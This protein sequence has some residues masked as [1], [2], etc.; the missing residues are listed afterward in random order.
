[1][2]MA[3]YQYGAY[4]NLFAGLHAEINPVAVVVKKVGAGAVYK[5]GTAMGRT[6][7]EA[8][9]TQWAGTPIVT[10]ADST[11]SDGSQTVYGI[12]AD[13]EGVDT[14]K[15]DVRATVY[16]TGEFNRDALI[17]GGTDKVSTH[18][19]AMKKIGILTKRVIY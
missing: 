12:L 7:Q 13:P 6:G 17:F 3:D 19:E 8:D 11:K 15:G 4:D 1:M 2:N 14:T 10:I 16:V 9:G 5:R 18:E